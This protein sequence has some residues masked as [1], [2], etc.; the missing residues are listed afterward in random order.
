MHDRDTDVTSTRTARIVF[1]SALYDL[2]VTAAF[3]TPWTAPRAFQALAAVHVRLG[4]DGPAPRLEGLETMLLANLLG[5]IVV[6]WSVVRLLTPT[7]R[8]GLADTAGRVLFSAWMA[9]AIA[10]G[11][12]GVFVAFLLGEVTWAIVQGAATAPV[13]RRNSAAIIA[14]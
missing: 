10:H 14:R 1:A 13:R 2:L 4:L 5:S 12:S 6:V 9:Y 3:A 11:A 8:L 7:A